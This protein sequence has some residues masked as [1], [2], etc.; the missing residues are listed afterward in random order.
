MALDQN[1]L[2]QSHLHGHDV[3]LSKFQPSKA[4]GLGGVHPSRSKNAPTLKIY[5]LFVLIL[6]PKWLCVLRWCPSF[7]GTNEFRFKDGA[8]ASWEVNKPLL[9]RECKMP[10]C[11]V[12]TSFVLW[13]MHCGYI[14]SHAQYRVWFIL[15][16]SK[17]IICNWPPTLEKTHRK[18]RKIQLISE[19]LNSLQPTAGSSAVDD[20]WICSATFMS[21][22]VTVIELAFRESYIP[23]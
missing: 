4:N 6:K 3:N 22:F 12:M 18:I 7:C 19:A 10:R 17:S 2:N 16:Q 5:R 9:S 15:C 11:D 21:P 20:D 13:V 14:E 23:Q 1:W 8:E